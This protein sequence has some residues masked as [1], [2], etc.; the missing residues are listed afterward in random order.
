MDAAGVE[1]GFASHAIGALYFLILTLMLLVDG[2]KRLDGA[3]PVLASVAT[4]LWLGAAACHVGF[5]L[6]DAGSVRLLEVLRNMAWLAFLL[7]VLGGAGAGLVAGEGRL[8][9]IA[10]AAYTLCLATALLVVL[11]DYAPLFPATAAPLDL[12]AAGYLLLAVV[13]LA[14]V[15]Q[16]FR[17]AR[18]EQR[19]RVKFLC[20]GIGGMFA[21]DFVLYSDA[22][23][24]RQV[25]SE[26]WTARGAVYVC[27]ALLVAASVAW[28]P[29][30]SPGIRVSRSVALYGTTILMAAVYLAAMLAAGYHIRRYG[31]DWGT[32][33]Q[34]VFLF[35]AALAL[36]L[37]VTSQRLRACLK[38]ALSKH[39]FN[40]KY[41]HREE[42]LRLIRTLSTDR[43]GPL[44]ERVI[45]ALAQIIDSPGGMLWTCA[46]GA[47]FVPVARW[48]M[49]GV[50][51]VREPAAGSLVRFLEQRGW[52]IDLEEYA[53]RPALYRGLELPQWLDGLQEPW[54]VVPLIHDER[55]LGFVVL[56]R[57][58]VSRS[59]DWEDNDL[60]KMAG[61][62][63]ASHLAHLE[64]AQALAEARQFETFNRLSAF[65]I[66]D[67]KNVAAQLSLVASN[68]ARH[69][70]KPAFI[71]DAVR[72]IEHS[73]AK[74]NRL[75][76]QLRD[77]GGISARRHA[78]VDLA[79]LLRTAVRNRS[80]ILPVPE[81]S[82]ADTGLW[83]TANADRLAA[84]LE[85]IIQNAQEATPQHGCVKVAL[86][87][88]GEQAVVEVEDN[89]CGMDET[90]VR[91]RLFRP[92]DTTK[93]GSGMGIGAYECRELA[94]SLGGDVEVWS[95]VGKGTLFRVLLPLTQTVETTRTDITPC[96]RVPN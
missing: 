68:A 67:I 36:L 33:A 5:G 28:R 43:A 13:G 27:A 96:I 93:G 71:D 60:L 91:E 66:H 40:Y 63:A 32:F 37:L 64:A 7:R 94:R 54:L 74:I 48:H 75:L 35:A 90:F 47:H 79:E 31:G 46:D 89:G 61:R 3:L 72:T 30:V 4:L 26:L 1:I 29:G 86:R 87:R 88:Q 52:V 62:Q 81:L 11:H 34:I 50:K 20:L 41:D 21:Y 23:L 22:L 16:L 9:V 10:I 84:V 65:V 51:N 8:R 19:W 70:H 6:P 44:R 53:A 92:F 56:R 24:F 17:N 55:L 82:L 25:N 76:G 57:A 59:L 15:E 69:R 58:P 18:M 83:V 38:V 39:F 45:R 78:A 14:L 80:Q 49:P 77:N 42:W 2:P 73:V 85:H 95:E 12:P